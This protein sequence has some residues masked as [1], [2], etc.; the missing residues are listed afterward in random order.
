M[1]V[2]N[3]IENTIH[4]IQTQIENIKQLCN[5]LFL[6]TTKL[7]KF[8]TKKRTRRKKREF[9]K[10]VSI[11]LA[12]FMKLTTPLVS[13]ENVLRYISNYVRNNNLQTTSD[14][15]NFKVDKQLSQLLKLE[16]GTIINFLSINKYINHLIL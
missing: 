9:D 1:D 16:I 6:E 4:N 14:K 12:S 5:E 13:R 11:E 8:V 2:E 15:R 3:N 7:E 10:N